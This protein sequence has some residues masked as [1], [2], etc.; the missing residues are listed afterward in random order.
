VPAIFHLLDDS[1]GWEHRFALGHLLERQTSE[2]AP[3]IAALSGISRDALP[4]QF[5]NF[6]SQI[7]NLKSEVLDLKR[8]F[9]PPSLPIAAAPS[10]AKLLNQHAIDIVHAW[11]TSAAIAACAATTKPVVLQLFDPVAAT[12]DA[13]KIRT[14][15]KRANFAIACG[16]AIIRRRLAE[17]GVPIE[18]LVVIRPGIDFAAISRSRRIDLRPQL[19]IAADDFVVLVP[20]PATH[21][22]GAFDVFWATALLNH[23]DGK[24]KIIVPGESDEQR[25]I[26][27][28]APTVPS[29]LCLVCPGSSIH[30]EDLIGIAD[31]LAVAPPGD[32]STT[33]IALAMAAGVPVIG[34]AVYAVAELIANKVNGL[35]FKRPTGQGVAVAVARLLADR[36]N[37]KRC[38]EAAHGQAF[39]VF[40]LRRFVDQT[41]RLY[42][43]L[44]RGISPGEGITD[45]ARTS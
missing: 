41:M 16:T 17:H 9:A 29:T 33:S 14:I 13:K 32:I 1:A 37:Q 31:I 25:R 43:N 4:S 15:S 40:G 26:A 34:S 23:V 7:S 45:S 18:K 27:E 42:E 30:F 10:L 20:E 19:G 6:N 2:R 44:P 35:L 36:E 8:I 3:F 12:R 11:G 39:Q 38:K 24:M 5:S 28:F 21:D 22:D